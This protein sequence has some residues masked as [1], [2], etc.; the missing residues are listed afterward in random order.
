MMHP[1]AL[2]RPD[3]PATGSGR[4]E[5]FRWL[6]FATVLFLLS[7][8]AMLHWG[9]GVLWGRVPN[10]SD[11]IPAADRA[12][13]QR[14]KEQ[15]NAR[16][17]V[18]LA[19]QTD[20]PW[21]TVCLIEPFDLDSA[22]LHEAL[23]AGHLPDADIALPGGPVAIPQPNWMFAFVRDNRVVRTVEFHH[24]EIEPRH[25]PYCVRR[26]QARFV[27]VHQTGSAVAIDL[28]HSS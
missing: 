27:N 5:R 24:R 4:R 10:R 8:T 9:M 13:A 20:F 11:V 16:H 15:L 14:F 1:P 17:V 22:S 12:F 28:E 18:A 21:D 26:D 6:M 23:L 3:R 25:G 19:A 7:S 2:Q